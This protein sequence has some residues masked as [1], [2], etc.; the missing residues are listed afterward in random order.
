MDD[1]IKRALFHIEQTIADDISLD[2]LADVACLSP[3]HFHRLFKTEVGQTPKEYVAEVRLKHIAHELVIK[4]H[5]TLTSTAFDYGYSSPAAFSRAF[6]KQFGVGP[7][8]FR[9]QNW[10]KH[11]ERLEKYWS[12]L[13]AG[14]NWRPQAIKL[15]HQRTKRVKTL[16]T[17]M[18]ENALNKAYKQLITDNAGRVSHG[19]TIYT[20]AP[21]RP[22]R[23][24]ERLFIALDENAN[25]TSGDILE[26]RSGYYYER[27]VTG[28][29][30]ALTDTMFRSFQRDIEPSAYEVASTTFYERVKLP[31]TPDGFDY[32]SQERTIFGCLK[33]R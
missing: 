14:E 27:A 4:K 30:D 16:R 19:L 28:D 13:E 32:F 15:H 22:D 21:F 9:E 31:V 10:E 23:H 17:F 2:D 25:E 8:T 33:R 3:H 6:K 12:E 5:L 1:R 29:F 11:K 20:E 18:E 24:K 7:K 26:L